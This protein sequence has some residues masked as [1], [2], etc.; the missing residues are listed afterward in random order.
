MAYHRRLGLESLR[1]TN[2]PGFGTAVF[3]AAFIIN[4]R[5]RVRAIVG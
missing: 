2:L 1:Y 4:E 3:V 5:V